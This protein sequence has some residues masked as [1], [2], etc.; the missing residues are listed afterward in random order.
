MTTMKI[1][2]SR[3][4]AGP[5]TLG[6]VLLRQICYGPLTRREEVVLAFVDSESELLG[7]HSAR[8][9]SLAV[10]QDQRT[11]HFSANHLRF[12]C[13]AVAS[14]I[15]ERA[16]LAALE[17][18][19]CHLAHSDETD[20]ELVDVLRARAA[21]RGVADPVTI[22]VSPDHDQGA[23]TTEPAALRRLLADATAKGFY[24]AAIAYGHELFSQW[25]M[26]ASYDPG[27]HASTR[28]LARALT[29]VGRADDALIVHRRLLDHWN[30]PWV[31]ATSYY[32]IA[33]LHA[34]H[35]G[36]ERRDVDKA[37]EA[38]GQA[39]AATERLDDARQR[40]YYRAFLKNGMAFLEVRRGDINA[41]VQHM[42][43]DLRALDEELADL[44]ELQHRVVARNNRATLRL[45]LGQLDGALDDL[46][47]VVSRDPY[48]A[49]YRMERAL[50]LHQAGR[51]NDALADLDFAIDH[52]VT[53]PEAYHNR[54]IIRRELGLLDQSLDDLRFGQHLDPTDDEIGR[55][56]RRAL[57]GAGAHA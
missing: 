54:A 15:E 46:D 28:G 51:V 16:G 40:S 33:M 22:D 21:F 42:E 24:S 20:R 57:Q 36:G 9:L 47:F 12:L 31:A 11:R 6:R 32:A 3:F 39:F 38:L 5:F 50:V 18:Q 37:V 44:S 52:C 45:H 26:P 17:L 4:V 56:L 55:D 1:C 7:E 30:H 27:F 48:T 53:G 34:R 10:G 29:A 43:G 14:I 8:P 23:P 41:A 2:A 49:E 35:L 19:V 25:H 13:H